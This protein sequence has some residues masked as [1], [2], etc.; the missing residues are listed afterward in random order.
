MDSTRRHSRRTGSAARWHERIGKAYSG[1][2]SSERARPAANPNHN[3]PDGRAAPIVWIGDRERPD[4][5]PD[6]YWFPGDDELDERRQQLK[7][8]GQH[9]K[10]VERTE[11]FRP[12]DQLKEGLPSESVR[13]IMCG[14]SV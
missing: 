10:V 11:L 5:D 4:I 3:G 7:L 14:P 9:L 1:Q 13:L 2:T 6:E 12:G 8:V